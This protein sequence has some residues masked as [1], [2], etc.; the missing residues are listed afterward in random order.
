ML[1]HQ[2]RTD[3]LEALTAAFDKFAATDDEMICIDS[4][5]DGV[6]VNALIVVRGK[7]IT[8]DIVT[9][10][11]RFMNNLERFKRKGKR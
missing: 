6:M 7:G 9:L 11:Y 3:Y 10:M 8:Y 2:D 1:D 4:K 5:Q